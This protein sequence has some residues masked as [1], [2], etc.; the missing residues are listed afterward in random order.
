MIPDVVPRP[1]PSIPGVIHQVRF[2]EHRD[3]L[4]IGETAGWVKA[5]ISYTLVGGSQTGDQPGVDETRME[6]A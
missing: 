6:K 1:G 4:G 5:I 3:V 2:L